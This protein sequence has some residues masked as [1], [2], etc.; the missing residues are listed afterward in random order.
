M[1]KTVVVLSPL[2]IKQKTAHQIQTCM[3]RANMQH[4]QSVDKKGEILLE[5]TSPGSSIYPNSPPWAGTFSS[6]YIIIIMIND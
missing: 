4:L 5:V 6:N 1:I 3:L 2:V